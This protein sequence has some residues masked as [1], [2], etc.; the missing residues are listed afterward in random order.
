MSLQRIQQGWYTTDN[1]LIHPLP[2]DT[3]SD[4]DPSSSD[5][6]TALS[7]HGPA[8]SGLNN[9]PTTPNSPPENLLDP[10]PNFADTNPY[11][12]QASFLDSTAEQQTIGPTGLLPTPPGPILSVD[13]SSSSLPMESE[14]EHTLRLYN[15]ATKSGLKTTKK[16]L[17]VKICVIRG[18]DEMP[19]KG[20][21]GIEVVLII[22]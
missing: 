18:G 6:Y 2:S 4:R 11:A 20:Y 19:P 12:H 17:L 16:H 7:D 14:E 9:G 10:Q 1:V 22:S 21:N 13:P 3:P 15:T 5:G 8:P